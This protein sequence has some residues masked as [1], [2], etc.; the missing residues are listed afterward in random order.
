MNRVSI[1]SENGL[2][3]IWR[4]AITCTN[5]HLLS[6]RPIGTNFSEI[7]IKLQNFSFTKMHPNALSSKW[8]PFCTEGDELREDSMNFVLYASQK[9][10]SFKMLLRS[11]GICW[12][13]DKAV[14]GAP[15]EVKS[16]TKQ[17][18]CIKFIR[19]FHNTWTFCPFYILC[20]QPFVPYFTMEQYSLICS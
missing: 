17:C 10:R 11:D 15:G 4:Q 12:H 20:F 1:A 13:K 2:S 18:H 16:L 14:I 8:Q 9:T 5:A 3:P 7:F 6:I 19:C